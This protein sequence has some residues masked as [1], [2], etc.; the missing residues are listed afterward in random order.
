MNQG[1]I[2]LDG[3]TGLPPRKLTDG[4]S[5]TFRQVHFEGCVV[6]PKAKGWWWI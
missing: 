6:A 4:L 5:K 3:S 1:K 2:G